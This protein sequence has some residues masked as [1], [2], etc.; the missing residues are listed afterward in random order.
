MKKKKNVICTLYFVANYLAEIG[1]IFEKMPKRFLC[2]NTR[3]RNRP[4]HNLFFLLAL[5]ASL[6]RCVHRNRN[7]YTAQASCWRGVCTRKTWLQNHLLLAVDAPSR[8]IRYTPRLEIYF[9]SSDGDSCALY[10]SSKK[11]LCTTLQSARAKCRAALESRVTRLGKFSP[12][13]WLFTLAQFCKI[14]EEAHNF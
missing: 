8:D 14:T 5:K 13:G 3:P 6:C 2:K 10:L 11:K 1:E 7:S 9:C 12:I 4:L